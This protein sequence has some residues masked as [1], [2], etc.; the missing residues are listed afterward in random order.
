MSLDRDFINAI[1]SE[2]FDKN[3]EQ[4]KEA[5][6]RSVNTDT[7]LYAKARNALASLS[8]AQRSQVIEFFKVV[9]ADSASVVL[10][11]LDGVHFPDNFEGDFVVTCNGNEIQGDLMDIF[12]ENAQDGGVYG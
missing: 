10:G 12:I 5:L 6:S 1:F 9:I 7:D 3:F 8:D 2:L 11:T 4:Y